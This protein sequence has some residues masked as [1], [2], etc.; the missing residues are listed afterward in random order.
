MVQRIPWAL[1][2]QVR[3]SAQPAEERSSSS[4]PRISNTLVRPDESSW[5]G[6]RF[7]LTDLQCDCSSLLDD[8]TL[9]FGAP[10]PSQ[11]WGIAVNTY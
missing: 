6:F 11:A 9:L 1:N 3:P 7:P 2:I 8:L 5:K 4:N 10:A